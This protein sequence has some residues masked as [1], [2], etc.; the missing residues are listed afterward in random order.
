M[1]PEMFLAVAG[2]AIGLGGLL[3]GIAGLVVGRYFWSHESPILRRNREADDE[4]K[5]QKF[6]AILEKSTQENRAF[7]E[8]ALER[9]PL[10]EMTPLWTRFNEAASANMTA[11]SGIF[12]VTGGDAIL[13]LTRATSKQ[14]GP[15]GASQTSGKIA[16]G[17][18]SGGANQP[19]GRESRGHGT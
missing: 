6:Q 16:E 15:G 18:G 8:E 11:A 9:R 4:K 2:V 1:T 3:V 13:T 7:L 17:T 10:G 12:K 19:S 5:L 14:P